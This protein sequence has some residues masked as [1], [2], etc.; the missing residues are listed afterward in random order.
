MLC[1]EAWTY[2]E[3]SACVVTT[4]PEVSK[5]RYP[6]MREGLPDENLGGWGKGAACSI[7]S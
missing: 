6:L 7:S 4:D 3:R 5:L 2:I 1:L